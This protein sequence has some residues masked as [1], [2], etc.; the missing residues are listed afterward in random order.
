MSREIVM[1]NLSPSN[2]IFRN[3]WLFAHG[4]W[5]G[6]VPS[7]PITFSHHGL[8][9]EVRSMGGDPFG[10]ASEARSTRAFKLSRPQYACCFRKV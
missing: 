9:S 1:H 4:A 2:V 6:D 8:A 10:L 5:L 3:P 7:A